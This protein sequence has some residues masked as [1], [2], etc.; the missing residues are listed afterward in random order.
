MAP[1]WEEPECMGNA[2]EEVR[3]DA[4]A[5]P[6]LESARPIG[7]HMDETLPFPRR[8][9][10]VSLQRAR[11]R[12][13]IH[14][15]SSGAELTSADYGGE[16]QAALVLKSLPTQPLARKSMTQEEMAMSP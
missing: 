13:V 9:L 8:P 10:Q 7:R 15:M 11:R 1:A 14:E 6:R 5:F 2:R 12:G 4:W 3:K 16:A